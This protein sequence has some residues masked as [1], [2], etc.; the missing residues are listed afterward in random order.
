M[1]ARIARQ[2]T[3][4]DIGG[5]GCAAVTSPPP[6][7][8]T[9]ERYVETLVAE[10]GGLTA[11][12]QLLIRRAGR[13]TELPEDPGSIERALRRLRSRGNEPGGQ[14]GR[15]LLKH[16]GVPVPLEQ[17]ARWM[18]QYHSRFADLPR[19]LRES[20]LWLWDRPPIAESACAGWIQ[21]GL[22]SIAL[23]RG[24]FSLAA[25][26]LERAAGLKRAESTGAE[27]LTRETHDESAKHVLGDGAFGGESAKRARG[28][29]AFGGESKKHARGGDIG[30]LAFGGESAKRARVGGETLG[31][32]AVGTLDRAGF[33][34]AEL[35][36]ARLDSQHGRSHDV[37]ERLARV[38]KALR[39]LR[40]EERECYHARWVDQLAYSHAHAKPPRYAEA[41][42][43]YA[44][45]PEDASS[46]FARFR[47]SHGL[48]YC[49]WKLGRTARAAKHAQA[50]VEHAG[51]AGLLRFRAQ[52]LSLW[53]V[54]E[55]SRANSLKAR[56][57]D[58]RSATF[59]E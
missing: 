52:A 31:E 2:D 13:T 51:D 47:R 26:R 19:S 32:S 7:G 44:S 56:I 23:E 15:W 59:D 37:A 53:A 57:R 43:L 18:G 24:Q 20:Q 14:Y 6:H 54:I 35:L 34:E 8:C 33:V 48:A 45:I 58:I 10:H 16:F 9:W 17:T 5:V 28:A 3:I 36:A 11:L 49:E 46:A 30:E 4:P 21:L 22:A 29:G 1:S 39:S 50:A 55:P 25:E 12:T 42:V 40:G 27:A 38:E 41:R